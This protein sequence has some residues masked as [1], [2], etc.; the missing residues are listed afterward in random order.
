MT[1]AFAV[2]LDAMRQA[3]ARAHDDAGLVLQA[4]GD[5]AAV[6]RTAAPAVGDGPLSGALARLA[7]ELD[8]RGRGLG[9]DASR[10][11]DVL[12]DSA[13]VYG[14]AEDAVGRAATGLLS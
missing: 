3:A 1:D 4:S 14:R 9:E 5:L 13:V 2:S 11:G 6:L 8:R 10:T 7:D 12:T